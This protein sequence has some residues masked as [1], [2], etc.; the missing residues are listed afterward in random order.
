[1]FFDQRARH[2]VTHACVFFFGELDVNDCHNVDEL[3]FHNGFWTTLQ[4]NGNGMEK[5][6]Q[7]VKKLK[8]G[9]LYLIRCTDLAD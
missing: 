3:M 6:I 2:C 8:S 9:H 5:I 1:M 7:M 4:W